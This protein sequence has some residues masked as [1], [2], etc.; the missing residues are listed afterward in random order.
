MPSLA[1]VASSRRCG[2]S[3]PSRVLDRETPSAT[4]PRSRV[5]V[6]R[7]T[8]I[9][10][11]AGAPCRLH[12]SD[13]PR[14]TAIV[15]QRFVACTTRRDPVCQRLRLPGKAD[16][17]TAPWLTIGVSCPPSA[18]MA[19]RPPVVYVPLRRMP[20]RTPDPG[21]RAAA[22]RPGVPV[23]PESPRWTPTSLCSH[24]PAG[25]SQ[26][27]ASAAPADDLVL[28]RSPGSRCSAGCV[29]SDRV[30]G[31]PR[32]HEIGF[33]WRSA[34]GTQSSVFRSAG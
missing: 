11:G 5:R 4:R 17:A 3:D 7:G 22:T 9:P 30:C 2:A 33:V 34:R 16:P 21:E 12:H 18:G 24:L 32:L 28:T 29:Y 31:P 8:S 19:R 14:Q 13:G 23:A 1:S 10:S 26:R 20:A 25:S 27:L 15:N 6:G